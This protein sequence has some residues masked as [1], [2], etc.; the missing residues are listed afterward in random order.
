MQPVYF[1]TTTIA[2]FHCVKR[3]VA[4][5]E[6]V[7]EGFLTN[8]TSY[9]LTQKGKD[10]GGRYRVM[11]EYTCIEWQEGSL[12]KH[13]AC[14]KQAAFTYPA[15]FSAIKRLHGK[16]IS[17]TVH[18]SLQRGTAIL[19]T[20]EQAQ[21]FLCSYGTMHEEKMQRASDILLANMTHNM[22]KNLEIIDYACGQG[23]ASIVLLN[24][25]ESQ[26]V[27]VDAIK[28][29]KLI[30]PSSI[31]LNRATEFLNGSAVIT[32]QCAKLDDITPADLSTANEHVKIHLLSN[33]LDMGGSAFN[34]EQLAK[35][36]QASQSGVNY[37]VC[38]SP[39]FKASKYNFMAFLSCFSHLDCEVV[40]H[41]SGSLCRSSGT[42]RTL[43]FKVTL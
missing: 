2:K 37:F 5:T 16:S 43:I 15:Q 21:Q 29:L 24:K 30:E 14:F 25:L 6:L 36:I 32:R 3:D 27:C 13:L 39:E 31:T 9:Q 18:N 28:G 34:V 4:F 12:L 7:A 11:P 42:H 35:N 40:V 23:L 20:K 33:I 10:I 1:P 17:D 41:D 8:D 26:G 19:T 38:V 22:P